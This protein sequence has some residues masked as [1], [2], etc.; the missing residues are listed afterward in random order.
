MKSFSISLRVSTSIAKYLLGAADGSFCPRRF[1]GVYRSPRPE[2]GLTKTLGHI[3][4][5]DMA[6]TLSEF[7]S[8]LDVVE[9]GRVVSRGRSGA[10]SAPKDRTPLDVALY[11]GQSKPSK[12]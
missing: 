10:F 3:L 7:V 2:T 4:P 8:N 5:I 9:D 1:A 11:D 6:R 12:P